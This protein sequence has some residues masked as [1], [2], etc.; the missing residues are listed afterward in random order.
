MGAGAFT[1]L[2]SAFDSTLPAWARLRPGC[3]VCRAFGCLHPGVRVRSPLLTSAFVSTLS[4]GARQ[5]LVLR[6]GG[7][8]PCIH[9]RRRSS[10][11]V[12]SWTTRTPCDLGGRF[13]ANVWRANAPHRPNRTQANASPPHPIPPA[14]RLPDRIPYHS[15]YLAPRNEPNA[16]RHRTERNPLIHTRSPTNGTQHG[17]GRYS[18][19]LGSYRGLDVCSGERVHPRVRLRGR[20]TRPVGST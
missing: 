5:Q 8:S 16:P 3:L 1:L 12:H 9:P 14:P 6:F 15:S 17:P 7:A 2:T 13:S 19:H 20:G 18:P 11:I 10:G 4:G